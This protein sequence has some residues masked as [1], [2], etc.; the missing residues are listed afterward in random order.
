MKQAASGDK[1]RCPLDIMSRKSIIQRCATPATQIHEQQKDNIFISTQQAGFKNREEGRGTRGC[2][3]FYP[4]LDFVISTTQPAIGDNAKD[5]FKTKTDRKSRLR[6]EFPC[7]Y[8]DQIAIPETV[9]VALRCVAVGKK[10]SNNEKACTDSI[11]R[12]KTKRFT[13]LSGLFA[14]TSIQHRR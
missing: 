11:T 10:E 7:W 12:K 14:S 1:E 6:H 9:E 5:P 8:F 2:V 13:L 4:S 3:K